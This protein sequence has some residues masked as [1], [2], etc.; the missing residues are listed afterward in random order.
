MSMAMILGL[1]LRNPLNK[2]AGAISELGDSY[3]VR[4]FLCRLREWGGGAM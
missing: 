4:I 2:T 1:R 3:K